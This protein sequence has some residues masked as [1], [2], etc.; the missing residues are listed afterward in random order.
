[1][2]PTLPLT[3]TPTPT[4]T[5]ILTLT[6]TLT[7]IGVVLAEGEVRG[8]YCVYVC[9]KRSVYGDACALNCIPTAGSITTQYGR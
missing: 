8:G 7:L 5:L 4:L 2:A 1:M 6:L 9:V 3:P